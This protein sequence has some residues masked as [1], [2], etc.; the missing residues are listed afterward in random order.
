MARAPLTILQDLRAGTITGDQVMAVKTLYPR[1]YEKILERVREEVSNP[2]TKTTYQQRL[3]LGMMFEGTEPTTAPEFIAAMQMPAE[4]PDD[5][6]QSVRPP[7]GTVQL[8]KNTM[9]S[10]ERAANR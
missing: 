5:P 2:E 7:G 6:G 10:T 1:I 3:K 9:T 4:K 8:S